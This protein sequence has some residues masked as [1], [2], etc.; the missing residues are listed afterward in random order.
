MRV[1]V[2]RLTIMTAMLALFISP[3]GMAASY[4][5]IKVEHEI[6]A[7]INQDGS[8][9]YLIYF[10]EKPKLSRVSS[11]NRKTR[12]EFVMSSLKSASENAQAG[13]RKY[14]DG[15]KVQ[16]KSFWIDN[17][18]AVEKSD[19]AVFEGLLQF[20]EIES[21]KARRTMKLHEPVERGGQGANKI[22]PMA[23][24]PNINHVKA[25]QVWALG[26]TGSGV[27]VANIDTGV[28][29]TH[30]AL[31]NQYRGN[32]GGGSFSH[33][34]NWYDPYG[35]HPASPADDNGHGSHTM[36]TV[37]GNDGSANQI[38]M[39]PGAQWIACRG[40]NASS[41]TDTALLTCAEFIAAPTDLTGANPDPSKR[42][43]VVNN[44]WGDCGS[45]YDSW[46]RTVVD[47]WQAA[48]I[49]PV[50]S[51]GNA[52]NCGYTSPPPC[53][54]V[55]NPGRYGN[56]TGVGSTGQT[57]GQYAT[58][59]N[60]GPTDDP[61]NINP[62]GY[63]SIK[64][65][66]AA[67]GVNIRSSVPTSDTS[68]EGGWSG[69]S[70]SAPHVTGLIALMLEAAPC[71]TYA[72]AETIIEQTAYLDTTGLPAACTGEGPG[73]LPNQATGW[74][75]IDALAAVNLALSACGPSGT[76]NG[77]VTDSSSTNPIAGA[78]VLLNSRSA[79]TNGSGQ[80][81]F[82]SVPVGS[83]TV[84]A[85]I[86]GY[87]N[88]TA[89]SVGISD[90]ATTTQNFALTPKS[91]VTVN[92]TVT[93]GSGAGWPLFATIAI[94]T[95]GFSTTAFTNSLTGQ[96]SVNLV[97]KTGFTFT[98]SAPGY[99]TDTTPVTTGSTSPV[100]QD[101]ALTVGSSCDAPG[102]TGGGISENFDS[103][104]TP[105][106]LP[107]GW[108][109]TDVS[110]TAG[111]WATNAGT[112]YPSGNPAHSSSNLIYF[113]SWT[114]SS[115]NSTRLYRI[116]GVDLSGA[117]SAT[118]SFWMYH[119]TGY[120]TSNDRVQV[121]VSTNG[122]SSWSDVGSPVS[123]YNGT[124]Q[125]T[126]HTVDLS[127]YTGPGN[128][129]VRV[130]FL[131]ISAYGNDVHI[132]DVLLNL[133][134]TQNAGGLVAGTVYDANTS[135]PLAGVRVTDHAAGSANTN[136]AGMFVFFS[137]AGIK[138]VTAIGP[139]GYDNATASVNV[140]DGDVTGQ[141]FN[142][143][144]GLLSFDP[145]NL[146]VTLDI[147]QT[148]ALDLT[149]SNDGGL[150][151]G[152]E[153]VEQAASINTV[154]FGIQGILYPPLTVKAAAVSDIKPAVDKK[155]EKK[156][157]AMS[158][159]GNSLAKNSINAWGTG[160]AM[161]G[162]GRYRIGSATDDT[163]QNIFLFGGDAGSSGSSDVMSYNTA[164]DTWTTG[165]A[166]IP[167]AG[168]SWQAVYIDGKYYLPGG[169]NGSHN[170]WLQI[171]DPAA[172]SWTAGANMPAATTPMAAAA[173]GKLYIFGGN[174]GPSSNVAM[175]DP[176]ANTWTSGLAAMPT[177]RTYGRAIGING[178]IYVVGGAAASATGAF[179]VYDP[180]TNSW[181]SGPSLNTARS[182][183]SL[184]AAGGYLYA[185]GGIPDFGT[186]AGTTTVERY[187]L[188]DFPGGGWEVM[189]AS[190][191]S[192]GAAAYGCA[193]D[194][195]WSIGG[196]DISGTGVTATRNQDEGLPCVC[197]GN[198]DVPWLSEN[199]GT[200]TVA[201]SGTQTVTVT[202]NATGLTYGTYTANLKI[203]HDTPYNTLTVP[204]KL[205]VTDTSTSTTTTV[206][207]STTTT[208]APSSTTTV[209]ACVDNDGDGYGD[210]CAKGTDCNDN[211]AFYTDVC[212]NCEVRIIPRALGWF[213]GEREKTR[214]LLVIGKRGTVFDETTPVRWESGDIAVVSQRV[215]FKR[216][217]FLKVSIDGAALAKGSFRALIG[218][219]SGTLTLVK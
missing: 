219:C 4:A 175:Y 8:A 25:D 103:G 141:N 208:V 213:L 186:W 136:A 39:A 42:P 44:S 71:L 15:H 76:L 38:G 72:E 91:Q 146:S 118:F 165:L 179:E 156:P 120:T 119:D 204:V 99:T 20:S 78:T 200:G 34:Y 162:A 115:T 164:T 27:V 191:D 11:L 155:A 176:A 67:P 184:F 134:C 113:N 207:P 96:Y 74:G 128:T 177:A 23:V 127:A 40:C 201:A 101:F 26:I 157:A 60:L 193:S 173:D 54:T 181:T 132:D 187:N 205:L 57:N 192:F 210:N 180:V 33:N 206:E 117:N 116:S 108:A 95:T 58:H 171:Y 209:P 121:Q 14:L 105:P 62:N 188:A 114:A 144:A 216:F 131:G 94:N 107:T 69:T 43:S 49:Y 183:M 212:P 77:T 199:P 140:A 46:Y 53:N 80:Y 2:S 174:P 98:V 10:C 169:Y 211:D 168:M 190:P 161:P 66:I 3:F 110:G 150:A 41:C 133:P 79:T 1:Q 16:Y 151:A 153:I 126:Q 145:P 93:D 97:E 35:D 135:L 196:V 178:F 123:R 198:V 138:D 102:Y 202:F 137:P 139:K 5:Q 88:A 7:K 31:V 75:E 18:I 197:A 182:D 215:F 189:T 30:Q 130:A 84:T 129:D 51:N 149:L 81:T 36:G 6:E 163:C 195:M 24:E 152:F 13:V 64:P 29:Y 143:P 166:A 112:R 87:D 100:T 203:K 159:A 55:G 167:N 158:S 185:S 22:V 82:T 122:G 160:T 68:Y 28:R 218:T 172:D 148:T 21:I 56:V 83:Y 214:T 61:D 85:A 86:F 59:S 170:N 65:Q 111:N 194:K 104:V 154:K 32:L 50:F 70:M 125:W 12:G 63:A 45:A 92:G 17:I 52:S 48:G 109:V 106:A 142:L 73:R 89:L 124:V 217:M 19:K 90:N 9:G 47:N 147:G 37:L